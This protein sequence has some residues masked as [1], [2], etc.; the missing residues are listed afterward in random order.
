MPNNNYILFT[1][2]I[3]WQEQAMNEQGIPCYNMRSAIDN[4]AIYIVLSPALTAEFIHLC[5]KERA[6]IAM[7]NDPEINTT[8]EYFVSG[9]YNENGSIISLVKG[10]YQITEI[11]QV[12]NNIDRYKFTGTTTYRILGK[13]IRD[14]KNNVLRLQKLINKKTG[15]VFRI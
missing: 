1:R 10:P 12:I 2:R 8:G 13:V 14:K 5:Y 6:M 7:C 9:A 11:Y 4:T 15:M 3:D